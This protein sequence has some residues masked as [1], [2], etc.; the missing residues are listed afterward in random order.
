MHEGMT[1]GSYCCR[2]MKS[3][4]LW[5]TGCI[6]EHWRKGVGAILGSNQNAMVLLLEAMGASEGFFDQ[7]CSIHG[8]IGKRKTLK[9]LKC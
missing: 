2:M 6:K 9:V 8:Q 5:G 4:Y 3:W 1:V 7:S